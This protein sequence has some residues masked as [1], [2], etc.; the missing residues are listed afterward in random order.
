M[1]DIEFFIK[2]LAYTRDLI[3]HSIL[4]MPEERHIGDLPH[5]VHPNIEKADWI[6]NEI[7]K[8]PPLRVVHHLVHYEETIAFPEMFKFHKNEAIVYKWDTYELEELEDWEK[9]K[10]T[11][12]LIERFKD[13]REKQIAYLKT[14]DNSLL[15]DVDNV[16]CWGK[17]PLNFIVNKTLQHTMSHGSKLLSKAI[18]WDDFMNYLEKV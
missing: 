11:E 1:N 10:S 8:W 13:I 7:G 15:N 12:K 5:F 18:F 17:L 4:I 2:Q 14:I 6:G 9:S 3:E 16:T